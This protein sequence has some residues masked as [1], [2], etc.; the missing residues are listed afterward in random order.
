MARI[1]TARSSLRTLLAAALTLAV[2]LPVAGLYTSLFSRQSLL[3]HLQAGRQ[4]SVIPLRIY[5]RERQLI[6][7]YADLQR[8]WTDLNA[9]PGRLQAAV[10]R[11]GRPAQGFAASGA[12][13][14]ARVLARYIL[15]RDRRLHRNRYGALVLS[16]YLSFDE[17]ELLELYLNSVYLGHRNYGFRSAA[18]FYYQQPLERLTAAQSAMLIGLSARPSAANPHTDPR[19]AVSNRNEVLRC[20]RAAGLLSPREYVR[21][22]G[23]AVAVIPRNHRRRFATDASFAA[24]MVR[25]RLFRKYG[26]AIYRDGFRV[27][28]TL[29]VVDQRS[30]NQAVYAPLLE[31]DRKTNYFLTEGRRVERPASTRAGRDRQLSRLRIHADLIPGLIV[32]VAED[33]L[34]VYLKTGQTIHLARDDLGLIKQKSSYRTG[35][36]ADEPLPRL[37]RPGA[38]VRVRN[39]NPDPQGRP[40]W[41][42]YRSP[43]AHAALV[44]LD[45]GSG[46][47][48]ALVGDIGYYLHRPVVNYATESPRYTGMTMAPF[49]YAA[50]LSRG[51]AVARINEKLNGAVLPDGKAL[52]AIIGLAGRQQ[53]QAFLRSKGFAGRFSSKAVRDEVQYTRSTPLQLAQRYAVLANGGYRINAYLVQSIERYDRSAGSTAEYTEVYRHRPYLACPRCRTLAQTAGRPAERVLDEAL[54]RQV[55]GLL[56]SSLHAGL[57]STGLVPEW[58]KNRSLYG[59]NHLQTVIYSGCGT[60]DE[61]NAWFAGYHSRLVVVTWAGIGYVKGSNTGAFSARPAAVMWMNYMTA[62]LKRNE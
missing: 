9:I 52:S 1:P 12:G 39:L 17:A 48:R 62:V 58:V 59:L 60:P 22:V 4:H 37:F 7:E 30:A 10:R 41:K 14:Y 44:A 35:V 21:A 55:G 46:A 19:Q 20:M 2:G 3:D 23:A 38:F 33:H 15:A 53:V 5:S 49:V 18:S 6:G 45:P 24:E 42:L 26:R 56:R 28:T 36:P 31:Y 34:R 51:I 40:I 27:Y 11:C 16:L 50:V 13:Y 25:R 43:G 8:Q 54:V 29:S 57:S 47:I 61:S 32:D